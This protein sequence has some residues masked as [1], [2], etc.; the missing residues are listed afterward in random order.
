MMQTAMGTVQ[1]ENTSL[2]AEIDSKPSV[3]DLFYKDVFENQSNTRLLVDLNCTPPSEKTIEGALVVLKTMFAKPIEFKSEV[4]TVDLFEECPQTRFSQEVPSLQSLGLSAENIDH[5]FFIKCYLNFPTDPSFCSDGIHDSASAVASISPGG[6]F[7]PRASTLK[8]TP[9][10]FQK[11]FFAQT[12]SRKSTTVQNSSLNLN[13]GGGLDTS[14]NLPSEV[15]ALMA[16]ICS[17]EMCKNPSVSLL[18]QFIQYLQN[19]LTT[20]RS[21]AQIFL[22]GL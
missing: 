7:A 19:G 13:E 11:L 15:H 12:A 4:K 3:I 14:E 18:S 21:A 16:K 9:K 1:A 17:N 10:K 5:A 22:S 20:G 6:A 8:K 2:K